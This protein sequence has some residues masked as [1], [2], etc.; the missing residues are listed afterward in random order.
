MPPSGQFRRERGHPSRRV[1]AVLAWT[2]GGIAL[3]VLFLRISL[4][5][6]PDSDAANNALQA[7]DMLHGHLLLHGWIIGDAT[8]Y[9]F[10]LPVMAVIEIFFGLHTIAIH[11]AMALI[12]LIIAACAVAIAVTDS[13]GA[14]RVARAGVTVA[15]LSAPVLIHSDL[16]IPLG[17][18]DHMGTSVFLLISCLLVDRA[19]GRRFTPPVLC[20]ILCA[21]Q[22]GDVTVRY[23]A[24]PAIVVMCAY[25]I[26]AARKIRTGDTANLVAAA[27]SL[28]LATVV[29]ALM[30]HFGAY[31]MVS[32]KTG[33]APVSHWPHNAALA[34]HSLRLLFG[35]AAAPHAAPAGTAV[36]FGSACL[37]AA[38][39][40]FL[41]ALR[42]WPAARRAEQALVVAIAVNI[43]A[44]VI[45][46]LPTPNTPHD[47]AVVLP[48][49][50]VLAARTLVPARIADMRT[51]LAAS[52]VAVVAAFL[53]LSVI[54]AQPPAVS[55]G[56]QLAGWLQA[57]GLRYGLGGYWDGSAVT[58]QAGGHVQ[59]RTVEV[60]GREVTPYPWETNTL[61]FDHSRH[62][63]NFAI[64]DLTNHDLGRRPNGSSAGPLKLTA[65]GPGR[66]SSTGRTCSPG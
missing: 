38:A 26:L 51:A 7:W 36:I 66:S 25:R 5:S 65:W 56:A 13:G 34:W 3:F 2:A 39:A 37:L 44:Y 57:H 30:R 54:A 46:T 23:V 60:K 12:Y 55:G 33:I 48:A 40:G 17:K 32:P 18:P 52:G 62:Y 31:L 28:P 47:L 11:V 45:S 42:R 1:L 21:G 6:V 64:I 20:V 61:W 15:V 59:V 9:T 14:S 22:I 16:W 58:V 4:T 19:T 43:G 35:S 63:A 24:V 10:E 29:R 50:A 8:Y 27:A 41:L 53:P 49:S